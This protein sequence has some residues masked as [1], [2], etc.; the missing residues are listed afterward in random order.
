M[1]SETK[2]RMIVAAYRKPAW[3]KAITLAIM[4]VPCIL[5]LFAAIRLST[6]PNRGHLPYILTVA[7][8]VL[9]GIKARMFGISLGF[10]RGLTHKAYET[11]DWLRGLFLALGCASI[12]GE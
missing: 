1:D 12:Q 3:Q 9:I 4:L 5:V 6:S 10:H 8:F 7:A 11:H 2:N